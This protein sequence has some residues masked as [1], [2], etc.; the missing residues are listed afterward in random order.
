MDFFSLVT[1]RLMVFSP[2]ER[3][4]SLHLLRDARLVTGTWCLFRS[5]RG[6]AVRVWSS[7]LN[8]SKKRKSPW[9]RLAAGCQSQ[10]FQ[11]ASHWTETMCFSTW[12]HD[13]LQAALGRG[14]ILDKTKP[15]HSYFLQIKKY[16]VCIVRHQHASTNTGSPT[17][18]QALSCTASY[19]TTIC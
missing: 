12:T 9:L 13:S 3:A 8:G 16:K 5:R 15:G 18:V 10:D 14:G 17:A 1:S 2:T 4:W 11:Y 19:C 7:P 6:P